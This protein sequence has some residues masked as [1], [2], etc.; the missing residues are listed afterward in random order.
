MRAY[1]FASDRIMPREVRLP[2]RDGQGTE[3]EADDHSHRVRHDVVR[4]A[5]TA[6]P[7]TSP[8]PASR[9]DAPE[10][11]ATMHMPATPTLTDTGS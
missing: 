9:C 2:T 10:I 5:L 4:V 7:G 11:A 1:P 8:C 6:A 3:Q